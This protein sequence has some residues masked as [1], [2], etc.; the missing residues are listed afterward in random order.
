MFGAVQKAV[1]TICTIFGDSSAS[2]SWTNG[3]FDLPPQGTGQGHGAGP[4]IWSVLSLI[5]FSILSDLGFSLE[6]INALTTEIFR[7]SGFAYVDDCDLVQLGQNIPNVINKTQAALSKWEALIQVTGGSLAP[8]KCWWYLVDHEWRNSKWHTTDP[9]VTHD[10]QATDNTGHMCTIKRLKISEAQEM[11]GVCLAP[12]GDNTEQTK[13]LK[14][15]AVH[16]AT[17]INTG[18]LSSSD[19]WT[20]MTSGIL[21]SLQYP[22][23]ALRLTYEE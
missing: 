6:F 2:Y 12:D 10:L 7:L 13:I 17:H 1:H 16:W 19:M 5:I 22:L 4:Q 9:D 3:D 11:L 14:D 18:C 20:S 21:K 8:S 23:P 15:K